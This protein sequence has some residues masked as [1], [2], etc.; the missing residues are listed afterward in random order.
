[1]NAADNLSSS[2]AIDSLINY[3]VR[4]LILHVASDL[5]SV[6]TSLR[7]D[8]TLSSGADSRV[9]K[10]TARLR[11]T[12]CVDEETGEPTSWKTDLSVRS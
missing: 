11:K 5:S 2:R 4:K 3:E 1:M 6:N 7:P 9:E 8:H 10:L 12:D